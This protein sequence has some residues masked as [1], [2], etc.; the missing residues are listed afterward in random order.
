M[1]RP[2]LTA[3]LLLVLGACGQKGPLYLPDRSPKGVPAKPQVTPATP[4]ASPATP[5]DPSDTRKRIP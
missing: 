3:T 4:Q 2:L 5:D 1:S